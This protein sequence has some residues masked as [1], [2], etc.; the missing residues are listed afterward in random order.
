[1]PKTL[2][3]SALAAGSAAL[4]LFGL[5]QVGQAQIGQAQ[6]LAGTPS[7]DP[8]LIELFTSQGCSS[9]PPADRLAERLAKDTD[10]VI[11]SRP[12]DYWDRLGWKDTLASPQNTDLQRRYA[13]RGLRGYNGVYTPQTVVDGA[14]GE[15]GSNEPGLRHQINAAQFAERPAQMHVIAVEGKGYAVGLAGASKA[16][17]ELMLMAV[18]S[19]RDI[20]IK[21]GENRGRTVRY[22]NA[23]IAEQRL[24]TWIGGKD[25]IA[26]TN[27]QLSVPGA[28]R[29]AVVLRSPRGGRVLAARWL[30]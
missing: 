13:R 26:L 15:V 23:L 27:E 10:L 5:S 19:S 28:D 6:D 21:R 20:A 7:D 24:H 9:C 16:P 25:S 18:A 22:T 3:L 8:V 29:Y 2:L 30:N 1:M 17:A 4:A 11:I 14:F 12:V